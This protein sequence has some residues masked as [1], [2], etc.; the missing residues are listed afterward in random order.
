MFRAQPAGVGRRP[1]PAPRT[2]PARSLFAP[3]GRIRL[4]PTVT[5]L[6]NAGPRVKTC[7][8]SSGTANLASAAFAASTQSA[9]HQAEQLRRPG[10]AAC[11]F[12]ARIAAV[13]RT[14]P[15]VAASDPQRL[16]E[17]PAARQTP[18]SQRSPS[19][20]DDVF[21]RPGVERRFPLSTPVAANG[22]PGWL[23]AGPRLGEPR[24]VEPRPAAPRV[25]DPSPKPRSPPASAAGTKHRA[26]RL[27]RVFRAAG[28]HV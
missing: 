28:K 10:A 24:L 16:E 25:I 13:R 12:A 9:S 15:P 8:T 27:C 6:R 20:L 17:V 11:I 2:P 5:G 3:P 4:T 18:S 19:E 1:A 26:R 21:H 22:R 14:A 7:A 23:P